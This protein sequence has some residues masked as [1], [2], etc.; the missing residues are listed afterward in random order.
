NHIDEERGQ[1]DLNFRADTGGVRT[2]QWTQ[3]PR[4][5]VVL[6]HGY[7]VAGFEMLPWAFLL[8]QEGWRCVLVDLRG[9]GKSSGRQIYFGIQE[10]RDLRALLDQLQEDHRLITPVSVIGHSYGAVLALR[11][12]MKDPRID[13]VVAISPYAELSRAILSVSEQYAPWLPKSFI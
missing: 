2:N 7:G 3:N 12:R 4:G 8:A 1:L 10:V 11:W 6:L 5:T 13:K 9:H